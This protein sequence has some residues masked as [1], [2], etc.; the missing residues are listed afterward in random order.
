MY[1]VRF[2]LRFKKNSFYVFFPGTVGFGSEFL[3]NYD[4]EIKSEFYEIFAKNM[5]TVLDEFFSKE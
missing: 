1:L 2:I 4:E 3:R 5:S